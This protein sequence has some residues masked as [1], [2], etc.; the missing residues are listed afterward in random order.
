M[1]V[2]VSLV[3]AGRTTMRSE[4]IWE[5]WD[6]TREEML[7][8]KERIKMIEATPMAMPKQVRKERVRL[9]RREDLAS[10]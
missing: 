9:R 2:T 7:P 1:L 10:W 8:I 6:E 5:T 4:P 3:E